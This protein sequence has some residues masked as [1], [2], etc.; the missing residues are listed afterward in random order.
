MEKNKKT[1]LDI[2]SKLICPKDLFNKFGKYKYRSCESILEAVKPLLAKNELYIIISDEIKQISDRFYVNA[3]IYLYNKED[4]L[5]AKSQAFAR[6]EENKKGMDAAQITGAASSYARKYAL[7]GLF[8]I[9]DGNDSDST[10]KHTD[11]PK[12][13]IKPLPEEIITAI[14]GFEYVDALKKYAEEAISKYPKN[15]TEIIGLHNARKKE[16][17]NT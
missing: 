2:Q 9:D 13:T 17:Q 4:V 3:V 8:A 11:E 12:E 14:K 10:N 7:C 6:E 5:I 1:L 16:I 15:K